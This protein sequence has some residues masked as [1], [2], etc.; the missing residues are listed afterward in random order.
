MYQFTGPDNERA[1]RYFER[2]IKFDPTFSRAYAGLSFTIGRMPFTSSLPT[3]K[4]RLIAPS[5]RPAVVYWRT[6]VTP[7]RTGQWDGR[8]GCVQTMRHRCESSRKPSH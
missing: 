7:R 3:D 1:Q 8:S 4:A 2:A 6:I 5:M